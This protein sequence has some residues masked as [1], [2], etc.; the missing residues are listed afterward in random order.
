MLL[1]S[2]TIKN[3]RCHESI[4]DLPIH[5]LTIFIGENDSG[6]TA[7]LDALCILLTSKSPTQSDFRQLNSD[8]KADEVFISGTFGVEAYDSVP[9][10]LC[11]S[12]GNKLI[13]TKRFQ[14]KSSIC[15]VD[16]LGFED[17]RFNSF[18]SQQAAIQKELLQN[19]EIEPGKNATERISQFK[20]AVD[21]N[22]I[23]RAVCKKPINFNQ[24]SEYLP[25]FE[26]IS[27]SEYKQPDS[28]IQRTLQGVVDSC[29]RP[30]DS[31][32][33]KSELLPELIDI[34]KLLQD[35]L[36][37]KINEITKILQR[38][39][40]DLKSVQ[41]NPN[42]DFLK[43]FTTAN[44][45]LD[46]GDGPQ[47]L[48]TFGEGTKK[49]VW[50][51]LLDWEKQVQKEETISV[52]RVYD[53][54]DINLDYSAERKLF[55]GILES[56]N[57]ENL[58]IQSIV[59]T[60]SVTLIDRAPIQSIR[61]IKVK[62][63]GCR[64]VEF[65]DGIIESDVV[66]FMFN[67]GYSVGISNSLVLYEKAFLVVEGES[68]ENALPILYRNLYGRSFLEDGIV[69]VNLFT[70]SSW[71]TTLKFLGSYRSSLT[72]VLLDADCITT[73]SGS[74]LTVEALEALNYPSDFINSNCFY[75]GTKE[76]EDAFQNDDL[77]ATL[78]QFYPKD[79]SE[80]WECTDI[81]SFREEGRKF[82]DELVQHVRRNCQP[83]LR[84]SMSKPEFAAKRVHP[85]FVALTLNPYPRAGEGL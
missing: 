32:T 20:Q 50:M 9:L 23:V 65:F 3:F 69:L 26:Y 61:L 11:S 1:Q 58:R 17:E 70:Y 53:E 57:T 41:V 15:E 12:D 56:I 18:E 24:I 64:E 43:S 80:L 75:I 13:L 74:R 10:D 30:I 38:F 31:E 37:E 73:N 83:T 4:V 46:F 84:S 79:N 76:F 44:L 67:V 77:L 42:I 14:E 28:L 55:S 22:R 85:T 63:G 59:S 81:D 36:N 27:S 33:Q 29:I 60:H 16:C 72:V 8:C 52:F 47:F 39:Y 34:R 49:K 82:G 78:N 48:N 40:P 5:K 35:A 7:I 71:K 66:P 25:R 19:L 6:K 2:I 21:S 45:M 51:C 68:E 54:P 62:E